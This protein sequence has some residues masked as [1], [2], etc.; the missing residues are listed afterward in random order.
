M[1][2]KCSAI[3][4]KCSTPKQKESNLGLQ[5]DRTVAVLQQQQ[6]ELEQVGVIAS[7]PEN[8][9]RAEGKEYKKRK[10]QRTQGHALEM[11]VQTF[12]ANCLFSV[13]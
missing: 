2:L 13:A 5:V 10:Q 4:L 9:R 8:V 1:R 7:K 12:C 11:R 6:L 3:W